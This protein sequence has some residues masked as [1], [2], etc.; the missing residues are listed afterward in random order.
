MRFYRILLLFYP[1]AFRAEYGEE[2]R[3]LFNERRRDAT[4]LPARLLLWLNTIADIL[5]SAAQTHWDIAR[6]DIRYA[7]RMLTRSPG[8]TFTAIVVAA[9]GIG[10]NTAVFSIADH[11]LVRPLPYRDASRLVRLWENRAYRGFDHLEPS[12]ANFLDWKRQTKSFDH[13]NAFTGSSWNMLENGVPVRLSGGAALG[14]DLMQMLGVQPELGRLLTPDDDREGAPA[15]IV[16]SHNL[17]V[18]RFGADPAI[19][20][21]NVAFDRGT[22]ICVGVM[23]PDFYFPERTT[24]YWRPLQLSAREYLARDDHYLN[25][26]A[27]LRPGVTIAQAREEM[28]ILAA[29]LERQYPKDNHDTTFSVIDLRDE[30]SSRSRLLLIAMVGASIG[31]LLIACTNLANLLLARALVRRKEMA[32]RAVLGAGRERLVRQLLTENVMLAGAGGLLGILLGW[33]ALPLFVRLV[34]N[35]L[36]I[37]EAPTLD[38]RVLAL[39]GLL[40]ILTGIGFGVL[41]A[42]R[43]C[44]LNHPAGSHAAVLQEGSRA[45][46]GGRRERLRTILVASAIT[47]SVVLSI[48]SG[49]L[50]RALWH[51]QSIDPG[52]RT[53][54]VL[55][56]RTSL[57]MPRYQS[58]ALRE[59]FYAKVLPEIRA[60][61]GVASAGYISRLPMA[62][63]GGIFR[64]VPEG[65]SADDSKTYQASLRHVTP[66]YFAAM[67]IP[68]TRGREILDSDTTTSLAVAVVSESFARQFWPDRDPIGRHFTFAEA[69]RTLVGVVG[70]VRVR[71]PEQTSEPQVYLPSSQ[72]PERQFVFFAPQELAIRSTLDAAAL[73]PAVRQIVMRAEAQTPIDRIRPLDAIVSEETA[74]RTV[75]VR[76]LG[77]FAAVACLLAAVGIHGLLAFAVSTRSQE[78][79][80]RMAMGAQMRDILRMILGE[81]LTL[82]CLGIAL[83]TALA[84]VAGRA[85]EA[86]LA[87]VSPADPITFV[88]VIGIAFVMTILGSLLPALRA[89]RVDPMTVIRSE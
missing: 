37:A 23:P 50:I 57:P 38:L 67:G 20:G 3:A 29:Q 71:G 33:L 52:F 80:V 36:P 39:A 47:V 11:V 65:F 46:V 30:L 45:G 6:Q 53:D 2:L 12:P 69:E 51:L 25:V 7:L 13:V 35:S 32:L 70:D 61:P 4:S 24:Q 86:L 42:L 49:L 81:S 56:M 8:F 16:L 73:V 72:M 40:T 74:P 78:I 34:P 21:R 27:K 64:V 60:L 63:K 31:V 82:A 41:P 55:T 15:V 19:I 58:T 9:L 76:V 10:A 1:A 44:R 5:V 26:I 66:G 54:H 77:V 22:L 85:M 28:R 48:A 87:G 17:W 68:L 89:V 88:A 75:Q 79:G 18:Q 62:F 83:G 43:A 14:G 59:R 84:Y